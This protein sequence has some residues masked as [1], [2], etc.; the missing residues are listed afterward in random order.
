MLATVAG[1]ALAPNIQRKLGAT[2]PADRSAENEVKMALD[3][4]ARERAARQAA[5]RAEQEMR[6]RLTDARGSQATQHLRQVLASE[7]NRRRMAE[8]AA[9]EAS[10]QLAEAQIAKD[11]AEQV[12]KEAH[13]RLVRMQLRKG[14]A[15]RAASQAKRQLAMERNAKR[16]AEGQ[17]TGSLP[18]AT[19]TL[20][21]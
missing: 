6:D 15:E 3:G 17:F 16:A 14:A 9:Q 20:P 5:E 19:T 8:K 13:E 4:L 1:F 2:L 18:T 12:A 7:Q 11:A 21:W 10:H